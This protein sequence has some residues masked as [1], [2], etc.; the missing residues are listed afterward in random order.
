VNLTDDGDRRGFETRR[1]CETTPTID[2]RSRRP[3]LART[4]VE[5][6]RIAIGVSRGK[7]VTDTD[8]GTDRFASNDE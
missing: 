7:R 2:E 4:E 1:P 3:A 6:T 5:S 8:D